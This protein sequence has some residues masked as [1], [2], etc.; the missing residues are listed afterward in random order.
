V[1]QSFDPACTGGFL[2]TNFALAQAYRVIGA[3]T[4]TL[5]KGV[6]P[7]L[8]IQQHEHSRVLF[9]YTMKLFKCIGAID[10]EDFTDLIGF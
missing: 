6:G 2:P 5:N 8:M 3:E 4:E 9:F 10:P 1:L 7:K